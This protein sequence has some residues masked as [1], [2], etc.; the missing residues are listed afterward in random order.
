M[1]G[2]ESSITDGTSSGSGLTLRSSN[3]IFCR[4]CKLEIRIA[5]EGLQ[6]S[7]CST[8]NH[9][10][11]WPYKFTEA[12]LAKFRSKN[13]PFHFHCDKCNT[14]N[15]KYNKAINISSLDE[16]EN[17]IRSRFASELASQDKKVGESNTMLASK[18]DELTEANR[19]IKLASAKETPS[20]Q[21]GATNKIWIKT[22]PPTMT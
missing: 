9:V 14:I 8:H 20:L 4:H 3:E 5:A 15:S 11:C 10:L 12:E 2:P 7:I 22:I 21:T 6:C 13:T 1:A 16:L 18:V 17:A 19:K